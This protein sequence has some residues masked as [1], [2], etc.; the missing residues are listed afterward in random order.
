MEHTDFSRRSFL[1]GASLAGLTAGILGAA[2]LAAPRTAVA[3][4]STEAA[5]PNDYQ[6]IFGEDTN[7]IPVKKAEWDQLNGFVA[8]D[9]KEFKDSEISRTDECDF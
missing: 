9:A 8:Y 5:S 6:K 2:E 4:E 3:A 7:Y 1:K